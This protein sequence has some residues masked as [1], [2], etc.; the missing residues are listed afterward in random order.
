MAPIST[1]YI[2]EKSAKSVIGTST[3]R[4]TEECLFAQKLGPYF[5][6]FL[7]DWA[8]MY[9]S[10]RLVTSCSNNLSNSARL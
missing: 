9:C 10:G 6:P 5:S 4:H 2:Y 8:A 3:S 1:L 7:A